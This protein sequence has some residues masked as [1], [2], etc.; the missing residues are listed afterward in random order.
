MNNE[1]TFV[2]YVDKSW[3]LRQGKLKDDL[4]DGEI[5]LQHEI[6]PNQQ[7]G[8]ERRIELHGIFT[9]GCCSE[10]EMRIYFTNGT[11][12]TVRAQTRL[13]G[14]IVP[15]FGSRSEDVVYFGEMEEL[16][17]DGLESKKFHTEQGGYISS[18]TFDLYGNGGLKR[19]EYDKTLNQWIITQESTG[20]FD[21]STLQ[22][23]TI[24]WPDSREKERLHEQGAYKVL[25]GKIQ[26]HTQ[27]N[28]N[29]ESRQFFD[30]ASGVLLNY[31]KGKFIDGNIVYGLLYNRPTSD[32]EEYSWY[33]VQ[34]IQRG[35]IATPDSHLGLLMKPIEKWKDKIYLGVDV[36]NPIEKPYHFQVS[37]PSGKL[38]C[39]SFYYHAEQ[40]WS[41]TFDT[42]GASTLKMMPIAHK[43]PYSTAI[44][45]INPETYIETIKS[46][47]LQ[48]Q[49]I[50]EVPSQ[51]IEKAILTPPVVAA[52]AEPQN[53][54][55]PAVSRNKFF[56]D[57]LRN[58][59]IQIMRQAYLKYEKEQLKLSV[60]ALEEI[61]D[62]EP[63]LSSSSSL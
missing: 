5:I 12:L 9:R 28:L 24:I 30:A 51:K 41:A 43:K 31:T 6:H 56:D 54:T 27:N 34:Y 38:N 42:N 26:L 8:T 58:R 45:T 29:N 55:S 22:T 40:V 44:R 53:S 23:G 57:A 25:N 13:A 35:G 59:N 3:L 18:T 4:L 16:S 49:L 21:Y 20:Y 37:Y 32:S 17:F 1:F 47:L 61:V 2:T 19:S 10:G 60:N 50:R 52:N 33:L 62:K 14:E 15:S 11:K 48:T 36:G 7:S 46:F 63:G 39:I